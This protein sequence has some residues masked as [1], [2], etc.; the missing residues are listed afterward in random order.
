MKRKI[1]LVEIEIDSL[2]RE[3]GEALGL[4]CFCD[5]GS[6]AFTLYRR[7]CMRSRILEDK[8]ENNVPFLFSDLAVPVSQK[9]IFPTATTVATRRLCERWRYPT[10]ERL[11]AVIPLHRI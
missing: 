10:T 11:R 1:I 3:T 2:S 9:L 4:D 6:F 7:A 5:V 8:N